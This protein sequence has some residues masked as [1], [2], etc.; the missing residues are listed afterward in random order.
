MHFKYYCAP[1]IYDCVYFSVLMHYH[2]LESEYIHLET[3]PMVLSLTSYDRTITVAFY[4]IFGKVSAIM[5]GGQKVSLSP[6]APLPPLPPLVSLL[7][8]ARPSRNYFHFSL[9]TFF[10]N[11]SFLSFI[12]PLFFL[13]PSPH[14]PSLLPCPPLKY[15]TPSYCR[16]L[17]AILSK[18][19]CLY[20]RCCRD[21]NFL[22]TCWFLCFY[23]A[24]D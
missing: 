11:F 10:L 12:P 2:D 21:A 7:G 18:H 14:L 6:P 1:D 19:V 5:R 3:N 15:R 8:A 24:I 23:F 22:I 13:L 20:S 9:P 17:N 16:K 4:T